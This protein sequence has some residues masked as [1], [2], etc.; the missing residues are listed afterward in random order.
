[1]RLVGIIAVLAV[2]IG[3]SVWLI[4]VAN[5]R[6]NHGPL[7]LFGDYEV[8]P[9]IESLASAADL[10]IE[11][12]GGPVVLREVDRGGNPE[13][14][15]ETGEKSSGIPMAFSEVTVTNIVWASPQI[16]ALVGKAVL[17]AMV[18]TELI[19]AEQ[20]SPLNE[21]EQVVL[22]LRHR[23]HSTAPGLTPDDFYVPLSGDNGVFDLEDSVA[24]PRLPA[25][26]DLRGLDIAAGP[27]PDSSRAFNLVDITQ[28]VREVAP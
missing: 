20:E 4:A 6:A 19:V 5:Q 27:T 15:P 9:S 13:S 14:D 10:V 7:M 25:V 17:V 3:A 28:V 12:Q 1:M 26:E 23:D 2:A 16:N 18:D 11:G 24:T 21:G 22:F 8:Y